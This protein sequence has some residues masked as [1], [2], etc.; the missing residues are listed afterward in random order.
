MRKDKIQFLS[1][2]KTVFYTTSKGF[3]SQ[4]F[5]GVMPRHQDYLNQFKNISRGGGK[6][7]GEGCSAPGDVLVPPGEERDAAPFQQWVA[8]KGCILKHAIL[9]HV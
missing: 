5:K 7:C 9:L 1:S 4:V 8:A 3:P 6:G 2:F